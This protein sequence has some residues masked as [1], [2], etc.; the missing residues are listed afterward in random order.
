VHEPVDTMK[1]FNLLML[2]GL[3]LLF[4][5]CATMIQGKTDEVTFASAQKGAS[6]EVDG[7]KSKTPATLTISKKITSATFSHPSY[8]SRKIEW[9]RDYQKGYVVLNVILTP[10]WGTTGMATDTATGAIWD[11]PK[12]ITY[13]FKTGK[14]SVDNSKD[15][16]P[17]GGQTTAAAG[18]PPARRH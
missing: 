3:P 6:V 10:G 16:K 15:Q 18:S 14:V 13:D 7:Q 4:N 1:T 12:T 17:P 5:S 9:K 8:A 11:Q 2:A